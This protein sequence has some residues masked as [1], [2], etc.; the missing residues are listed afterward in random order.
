MKNKKINI[1]NNK[2]KNNYYYQYKS[3]IT[4]KK[5]IRTILFKQ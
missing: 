2:S 4:Y 3:W 5:I 1:N